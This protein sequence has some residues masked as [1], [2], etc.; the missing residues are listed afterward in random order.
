MTWLRNRVTHIPLWA[1]V[2]TLRQYV[3]CYLLI[4]IGEYLFTNKSASLVPLRWLQLLEDFDSCKRLLWGS[5]L[6]LHTNYSLCSA[7]W[8]DMIN[9]VRCVPLVMS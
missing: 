7:V 2:G 1:D 4:L 3:R 8:R 9:I 6:L 5:A